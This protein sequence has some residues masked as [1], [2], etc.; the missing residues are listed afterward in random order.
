MFVSAVPGKKMAFIVRAALFAALMS[1]AEGKGVQASF[2][3]AGRRMTSGTCLQGDLMAA[4]S[5]DWSVDSPADL[6]ASMKST[7]YGGL[8][9]YSKNDGSC[10]LFAS[11]CGAG[12]TNQLFALHKNK[13]CKACPK[14]RWV[15][16]RRRDA[17]ALRR[18]CCWAT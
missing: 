5:V 2:R 17:G 4:K 8:G 14:G 9:Q 6:V 1:V 16:G 13:Q 7:G 15:S 10:D 18:L 12:E 11:T 3:A